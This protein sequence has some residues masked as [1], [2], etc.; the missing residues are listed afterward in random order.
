MRRPA[1]RCL[2]TKSSRVTEYKKGEYVA[3]TDDDFIK[4]NVE[5]TQSIDI[6]DFVD[7]ADISP[8]YFDKPYYLAPLKKRATRLCAAA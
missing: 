7:A 6:L 1:G 3:L 2:G 5:A 8:I 4:A